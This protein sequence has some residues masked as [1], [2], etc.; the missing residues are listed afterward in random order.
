[1]TRGAPLKKKLSVILK[2]QNGKQSRSSVFIE[3]RMLLAI[4][5]CVIFTVNFV[6]PSVIP[7]FVFQW[8]V[9]L[10]VRTNILM[11]AQLI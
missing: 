7:A 6:M 8:E 9:F 3:H 10:K 1:M 11:A 4:L 5:M 2:L